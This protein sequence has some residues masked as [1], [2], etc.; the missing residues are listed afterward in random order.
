MDLVIMVVDGRAGIMPEDRIVYRTIKQTGL[1][2][3]VV[4]NKCD[5]T[6]NP[7]SYL[8]DFYEF[9]ED[10]LPAAFER[11]FNIDM[12]VEWILARLGDE[13]LTVREGFRLA[14]GG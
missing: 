11:D 7:E 9:G 2:F 14:I 12:I 8:S 10:L 6:L 4:V 3:L 5:K 1:P 13:D